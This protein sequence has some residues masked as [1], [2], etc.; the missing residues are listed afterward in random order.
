MIS[1]FFID[2]HTSLKI[3]LVPH[4]TGIPAGRVEAHAWAELLLAKGIRAILDPCIRESALDC[5]G[6]VGRRPEEDA[7]LGDLRWCGGGV[8]EE[9]PDSVRAT[10]DKAGLPHRQRQHPPSSH[11]VCKPEARRRTC[12]RR[13]L[14]PSRR[15]P[16]Q[17]TLLLY[18]KYN[19]M[20]VY[21]SYIN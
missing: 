11:Q 18:L 7:P 2:T 12:A 14:R 5:S 19:I 3:G 1:T 17:F 16:W 13:A 8:C 20:Y 6:R 10:T 4:H 15:R 21:D 9:T